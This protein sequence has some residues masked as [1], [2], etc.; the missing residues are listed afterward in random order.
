MSTEHIL[1]LTNSSDVT[2]DYLCSRL[3]EGGIRFSRFD[4]DKDCLTSTFKYQSGSLNLKWSNNSLR[5]EQITTVI[6]RRPKPLQIHDNG[7]KYSEQHTAKEWSEVLEGFLAHINEKHWINH[8]ARNSGASH[9]VEQLSRAKSYGLNIPETI[10]TNDTSKAKKFL[11]FHKCGV[12]V[13]PLASGFIERDSPADDTV[14][15]TQQFK[16]IHEKFLDEIQ[17]C[18]VLFQE[19][20]PKILDVRVTI[21]DGII[22]ST[23]LSAK[24]HDGTQRLDVRRDNMSNVNYSSLKMPDDVSA[25]VRSYINSYGL[26]FAA[27]DFGITNSGKWVFF[28]INPNGQ[29]AWLDLYGTTDIASLFIKQLKK[30]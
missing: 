18:P 26:R 8:P 16:K 11:D 9:K 23:G 13:K 12:I 5:P 21:L 30:G 4:T 19:M 20:I 7:D 6:L 22:V 17:S 15:Y 10:V 24:E 25:S 28:E 14:I 29:W 1:V 2:S 3:K 27:I